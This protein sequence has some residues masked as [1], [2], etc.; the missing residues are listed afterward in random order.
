M[1]NESDA[2][3]EYMVIRILWSQCVNTVCQLPDMYNES[4]VSTEI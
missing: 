3:I 4:Y 1:V 2:A